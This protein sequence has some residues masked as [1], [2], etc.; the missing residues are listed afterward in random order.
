LA[1]AAARKRVLAVVEVA[2]YPTGKLAQVL[3]KVAN[4]SDR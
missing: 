4:R 1:V 2:I 3:A